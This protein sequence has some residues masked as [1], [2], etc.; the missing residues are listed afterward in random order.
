MPANRAARRENTHAP[1]GATSAGS[2]SHKHITS[3]GLEDRREDARLLPA[4]IAAGSGAA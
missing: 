1:D 2:G 3:V 4:P